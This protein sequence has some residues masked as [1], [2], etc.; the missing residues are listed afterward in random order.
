MATKAL[1]QLASG[2]S[3]FINLRD[4]LLSSDEAQAFCV[5][6]A[7]TCKHA[8]QQWSLLCMGRESSAAPAR[9]FSL[10]RVPETLRSLYHCALADQHPPRSVS[11]VQTSLHILK[12]RGRAASVSA[13]GAHYSNRVH[14][15]TGTVLRQ[16]PACHTAGTL[17]LACAC[18]TVPGTDSRDIMFLSNALCVCKADM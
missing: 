13:C 14:R 3:L 5:C 17:P 18:T 7:T 1:Q 6:E 12:C 16:L 9:H 10:S 4:R 2:Q 8:P 11:T 15:R